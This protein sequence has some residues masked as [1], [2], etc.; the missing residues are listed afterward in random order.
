MTEYESKRKPCRYSDMCKHHGS[1]VECKS[2]AMRFNCDL[3]QGVEQ[4]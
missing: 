4:S 3:V 2:D 1:R